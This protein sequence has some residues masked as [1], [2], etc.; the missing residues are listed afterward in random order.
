MAFDIVALK[1]HKGKTKH[2]KLSNHLSNVNLNPSYRLFILRCS[3]TPLHETY[4]N[5]RMQASCSIPNS[6][7]VEALESLQKS[8]AAISL[9]VY[10]DLAGPISIKSLRFNIQVDF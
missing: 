7:L 1:D 5:L 3:Y 4:A 2:N 8:R 6:M 9:G 10:S